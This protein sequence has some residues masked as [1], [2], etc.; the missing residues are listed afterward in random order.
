MEDFAMSTKFA[1]VSVW[2]EDI[3]AAVRFYREVLGLEL[4][5]HHGSRPHFRV[6]GVYL[7][8]LKGT[9][10]STQNAEPDHF[11]LFALSVD[12]LDEMVKRLEGHH[13]ALPWGVVSSANERWVLFHDPAGNVIELIQFNN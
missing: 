13:I 2:A 12:N 9:S 6:N 1:V 5:S 7:T 10:V 4:A 3:A 11:P 8:V